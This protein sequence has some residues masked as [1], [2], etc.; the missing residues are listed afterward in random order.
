MNI[1]YL[2]PDDREQSSRKKVKFLVSVQLQ[3]HSWNVDVYVCTITAQ[4]ITFL[5]LFRHRRRP[6]ILRQ[7]EL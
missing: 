6:A 4:Y 7:K 3:M 1:P 5:L 2:N